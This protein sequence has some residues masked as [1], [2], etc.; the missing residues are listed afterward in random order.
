M[1][2]PPVV[3][4]RASCEQGDAQEWGQAAEV[5]VPPAPGAVL[6]INPP[7]LPAPRAGGVSAGAGLILA[8]GAAGCPNC[9][10]LFVCAC[11]L[12]FVCFSKLGF[13]FL[14]TAGFLSQSPWTLGASPLLPR[15]ELASAFLCRSCAQV[16][17]GG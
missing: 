17:Q 8:S 15:A 10:G 11:S 9:Q 1:F 16:C 14:T 6:R 4:R 5:A 2:S 13:A 7:G 12:V 3:G